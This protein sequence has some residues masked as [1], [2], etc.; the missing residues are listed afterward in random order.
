MVIVWAFYPETAGRSLEEVE[1]V[2]SG[3]SVVEVLE[4]GSAGETTAVATAPRSQIRHKGLHP[5]SMH[6]TDYTI[7]SVETTSLSGSEKGMEVKEL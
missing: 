4:Q 6:P 1:A 2:F 5:L 7:S 3:E